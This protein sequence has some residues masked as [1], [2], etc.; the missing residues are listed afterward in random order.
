MKYDNK[1]VASKLANRLEVMIQK[2]RKERELRRGLKMLKIA[3]KGLIV[4]CLF[5][6]AC[7][8]ADP[9]SA[10]NLI[11]GQA[12]EMSM[13]ENGKLTITHTYER[14]PSTIGGNTGTVY[15][16]RSFSDWLFSE[17]K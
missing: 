8:L 4:S 15:N 3:K 5:L 2:D 17:A 6:S 16:R 12:N 10:G 9:A 11:G 7:S 14:T 1:K 13:P